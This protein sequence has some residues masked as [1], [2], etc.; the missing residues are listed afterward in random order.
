MDI[1][2]ILPNTITVG[3]ML[4][5]EQ[6]H[7]LITSTCQMNYSLPDST[8]IS[9]M[10]SLANERLFGRDGMAVKTTPVGE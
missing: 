3:G 4:A 5:E 8:S 1:T 6:T 7:R 2:G 10:K 9:P